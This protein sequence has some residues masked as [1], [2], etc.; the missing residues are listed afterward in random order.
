MIDNISLVAH[1]A[2][3]IKTNDN[4]IIYFDP[5][6][7]TYEYMKD[8]DY[9][10]ITHSHYDHFSI[11]DINNI[12][13]DN[14]KIII[15][16]DIVNKV[17]ELGFK[18]EDILLVKPNYDYKIDNISF[19]TVPAYNINKN[20]HKKEYDWVGYLINIDGHILYIAGDT[21][22]IP[23][24]RNLKCDIAFVPVGGTYTMDAN[25]AA[26]LVKEIKPKLAVPIHYKTIVGSVEDAYKF[27][28]LLNDIVDVC[29]LMK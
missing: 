17:V 9:I 27:K 1:S 13:K 29:V 12:K 16:C 28:E 15:T 11:Q 19:N 25:E 22:N 26:Y 18:K 2:I 23:E 14:T 21:D 5:Y 10:F 3:R 4:K 6:Q 8:S 7:I 24:I 20:F